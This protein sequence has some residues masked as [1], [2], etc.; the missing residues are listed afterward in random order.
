[1]SVVPPAHGLRLNPHPGCD[2]LCSKEFWA[3][4]DA[5][6]V[7]AALARAPAAMSY[8]GHVL[9]L[10]VSAGAKA[11]GVE[12]LLRAGAPPNAREETGDRRYVLQVAVLLGT[13]ES[14]SAWWWR[15]RGDDDSEICRAREHEAR[16]SPGIVSALL[17]AGADPGT[18]DASGRTAIDLARRHGN[19]EALALLLARSDPPATC[20]RLC[21]AEFWQRAGP[22]R[23][24][25]ALTQAGTARG[26][27]SR[28][29]TPLHLALETGVG[30]ELVTVLLEA[31]A[32]PNARNARDDTPL[33]VA[34]VTAGSAAAIPILLEHGAMLEVANARDRT[35]L[36]VATVHAT[37]LDAMRALLEAGADPDIR[38]GELNRMTP[39]ELAARQPEGPE[40]TLLMLDRGDRADVGSAAGL[41]PLLHHAA[42]GHPETVA[43]LLDRGADVHRRSAFGRTAILSAAAAGNLATA[44]VLL[45][46]GADPHWSKYDGSA[47]LSGEGE[48]PLH[49]AVHFPEVVE[50]LLE[51]GADPDGRMYFTGETPLH[52][53]A[54]SC[55]AES[56]ALLLARGADPN[57]RDGHGDTPLSR[58]VRRVAD[59]GKVEWE[60]WRKSCA[61]NTSWESPEQCRA[62]VRLDFER[63]YERREECEENVSA[64]VRHGA[65]TDIPGYGGP[66]LLEQARRLAIAAAQEIASAYERLGPF[67]HDDGE[68]PP[69]DAAGS[70]AVREVRLA[71]EQGAAEAQYALG[72][73]YARGHGAVP[74][75]EVEALRWLGLA[76]GQGLEPA[77]RELE[78]V[79]Q[80]MPKPRVKCGFPRLRSK[81]P[82]TGA[83]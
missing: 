16:R 12:A 81:A 18:R 20:G 56:L 40:A 80:A 71:A 68:V 35:P 58:A 67:D 9:R 66:P 54:A 53:A 78:R 33:H 41:Q 59:S 23:V 24:R 11:G 14:S 73:M 60:T 48:R 75:D 72:R 46:R 32:D 64:L 76:A 47:V 82:G 29:D 39:R 77:R 4:A 50:L 17:A 45:A 28:G 44:R 42:V 25:A 69:E 13:E 2:D 34:A 10:A 26:R 55:E 70:E 49:V 74:Q 61:T 1:M 79:K 7:S 37:T 57:A 22:E 30:A 31:G 62:A 27:S 3:D 51:H 15:R 19:D 52:L 83:E 36:Y 21:T 38:S 8:R 63:R 65:R 43:M 6:D 5:D